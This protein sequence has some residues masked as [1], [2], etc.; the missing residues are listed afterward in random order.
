MVKT[1]EIL[2]F[3]YKINDEDLQFKFIKYG[4]L[5]NKVNVTKTSIDVG[6]NCYIVKNIHM[7]ID[8]EEEDTH[9][10]DELDFYEESEE[11]DDMGDMD[12]MYKPISDMEEE[13]DDGDDDYIMNLFHFEDDDV[14]D[15]VDD[16]DHTTCDGDK[17]DSVEDLVV[18][19]P[20]LN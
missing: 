11:S 3:K 17:N 5:V 8:Y 15:V 13:D 12:D 2:V 6:T 10:K 14:N 20:N 4:E 9:S 1:D 16:I 19:I 7:S 18:E